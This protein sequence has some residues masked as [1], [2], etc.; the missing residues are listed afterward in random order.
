MGETS[1]TEGICTITATA[2]PQTNSVGLIINSSGYR[3]NRT[4]LLGNSVGILLM[5][6]RHHARCTS[7]CI[8]VLFRI[9]A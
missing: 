3:L 5:F 6:L 2:Q 8:V 9:E 7:G 4:R 1:T